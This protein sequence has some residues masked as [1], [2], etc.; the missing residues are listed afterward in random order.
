MGYS[1]HLSS[2]KNNSIAFED[3]LRKC[4]TCGT[5]MNS[6]EN[7]CRSQQLHGN[8]LN[9][10][11]NNHRDAATTLWHI[12]TRH[13]NSKFAVCSNL[14]SG[15]NSNCKHLKQHW[16][17][18]E[19]TYKIACVALWTKQNQLFFAVHMK[20]GSYPLFIVARV[21]I[22]HATEVNNNRTATTL[23]I[24]ANVQQAVAIYGN[25]YQGDN[26]GLIPFISGIL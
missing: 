21:N 26:A 17:C 14:L 3:H 23:V 13:N 7:N 22:Q 25:N 10:N 8:P 16:P 20:L 12:V 9:N 24:I 4:T 18:S 11:K 15:K 19:I 2:N 6:I 1:N 5:Q